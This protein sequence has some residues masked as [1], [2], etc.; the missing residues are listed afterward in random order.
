VDIEQYSQ[1][2]TA[3]GFTNELIGKTQLRV[4]GDANEIAADLWMVASSCG[5][6]IQN[7]MPS[8]SSLE[9]VFLKAVRENRNADS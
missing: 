2:L 9:E 7:L 6:A 5:V 8:Q 4:A 3:A 1:A